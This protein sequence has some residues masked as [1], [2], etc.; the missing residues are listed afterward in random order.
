M[1]P[2]AYGNQ[3]TTNLPGQNFAQTYS[4]D[5]QAIVDGI[6]KGF[7]AHR[8][9]RLNF[10]GQWQEAALLGWPE[11]SNTFFFTGQTPPGA[12]K[13]Q[14]QIDSSVSIASHRFAALINSLWTPSS[15]VW[16]RYVHPDDYVM[17]QRGATAF[18]DN[19]T[20]AVWRERYKATA[21]FRSQNMQNAQS[22]GMFGNMNMY[23]DELDQVENPG[24]R[25]LRYTAI[26][27]G[28]IWYTL[29]QQGRVCGYYR[30]WRWTAQQHLDEY[31]RERFPDAL[32]PSLQLQSQEK[33]IVI[34]CV[35]RR[36][37]YVPYRLDAKGKRWA[38][39]HVSQPGRC[40]L[41]EDGYRSFPVAPG[42]YMVAPF[43][44]YGRGPMQIVLASAKTKNAQKSVY[45]RQGH[46]AGDPIYLTTDDATFELERVP[47]T[48]NKGGLS[49]DGRRLADILPT[50]NIQITKEMMDE[51][52]Q[53]I[54]DAFLVGLYRLLLKTGEMPNMSARQVTEMIEQRAMFLAPVADGPHDEYL[55]G[56]IPRELD[57]LSYQG[58]LPMRPPAL[59]EAGPFDYDVEYTNPMMRMM[60]AGES[61][62]FMQMVEMTT[63][64]A[65]STGD[66][67]V[68]N[69]Y[70]FPRAVA[71]MAKN[72]GVRSDWL[73]TPGEIA[74]KEKAAAQQAERDQ[75]S[76]EMP[77]QAAI[78]KAQAIQ[79][80]A[81]AGQNIG[82]TLSGMAPGG[83]P[84]IP[85]NPQGMP[86][87][88]GIG[89]QPGVS[90]IPAPPG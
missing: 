18:Y 73:S 28:Q 14:Q 87:Q 34:E 16:T 35:C 44:D 7:E 69:V 17:K 6:L 32:R 71:G 51:E 47:G 79:A 89:G 62:A 27:V 84:Q 3:A 82:G 30:A 37:D 65:Q 81:Q 67:S 29:D 77:A 66:A 83:M 9:R 48:V 4:A 40:L 12:K 43:E 11:H 24:E 21:N 85:G 13:A 46:L 50:G 86:G 90:G 25:G 1:P 5:E 39:Y 52:G 19:L 38:S 26:P 45:L 22:L 60:Q 36:T 63:Q 33:F 56:I 80:K 8:T 42:R 10:D 70:N 58:L 54:D 74:A 41:K 31:G 57:V 2:D 61:A 68:W 64:V 53:I 72:R 23:I 49:G 78:I 76:K 20:R 55:G 88:P 59:V 15:S 75:R